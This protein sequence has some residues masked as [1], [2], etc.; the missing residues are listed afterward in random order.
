MTREKA[1][2][3]TSDSAL[4]AEADARADADVRNGRLISHDAVKRWLSSWGSAKPLPRPRV[5]D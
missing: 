5:G 4:E 3:E 1:L 2:F